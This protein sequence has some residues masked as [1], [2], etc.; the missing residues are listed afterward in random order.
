MAVARTFLLLPSGNQSILSFPSFSAFCFLRV[1]QFMGHRMHS[2]RLYQHHKNHSILFAVM[3]ALEIS[4]SN[5][6]FRTS[7]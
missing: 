1:Q 4:K 5:I 6:C 2:R 3:I 7:C